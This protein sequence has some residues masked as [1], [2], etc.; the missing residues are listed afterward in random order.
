[1]QLQET[2]STI[3]SLCEGNPPVKDGS[4]SLKDSNVDIFF[5]VE[6]NCWTNRRV[7]SDME[8]HDLHV[9]LL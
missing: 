1:M 5:I 7:A 2:S 9:T 4:P 8:C 3:L 6:P